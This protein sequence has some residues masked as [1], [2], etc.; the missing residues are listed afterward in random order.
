[1]TQGNGP[2]QEAGAGRGDF[3]FHQLFPWLRIFP[4]PEEVPLRSGPIRLGL[5]P[6][7]HLPGPLV[8]RHQ[9]VFLVGHGQKGRS[10]PG[11]YVGDLEALPYRYPDLFP[12][13]QVECVLGHLAA[14]GTPFENLGLQQAVG[15][16]D[17]V[18]LFPHWDFQGFGAQIPATDHKA[19]P[20]GARGAAHLER[21]TVKKLDTH[22]YLYV[23]S[24][25]FSP[26]IAQSRKVQRFVC[27]HD[28]PPVAFTKCYLRDARTLR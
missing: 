5:A 16:D 24:Q 19:M 17:P 15:H 8:A 11:R 26:G 4:R 2:D 13:L 28:N 10:A 3:Y 9:P 22:R 21:Q 6:A 18:G 20:S 12:A 23:F 25:N 7:G 27:I 1:M 14:D